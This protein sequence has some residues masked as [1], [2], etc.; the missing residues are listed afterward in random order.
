MDLAGCDFRKFV[1]D[2]NSDDIYLYEVGCGGSPSAY[3]SRQ[4]RRKARRS[5]PTG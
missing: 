3:R 5:D 1:T 4:G 2:E